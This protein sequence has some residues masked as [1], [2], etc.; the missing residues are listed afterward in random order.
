LGDGTTLTRS[1]PVPLAL[2]MNNL[3]TKVAVGFWHAL[4][5][6]GGKAF[7]FGQNTVFSVF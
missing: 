6:R 5:I 3:V 7:T 1:T 2:S 4:V